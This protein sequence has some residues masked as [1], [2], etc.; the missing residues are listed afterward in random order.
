MM[1]QIDV[2]KV[3]NAVV[4]HTGKKVK[5]RINRGRHRI[6]EAE[7]F[8]SETYPSVFTIKTFENKG[9]P[10]RIM[11]YSYTDVFTKDVELTLCT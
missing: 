1:K 6:D 9:M 8:I 10:E 7:G 11:A 4:N 2:N 3:R 5:I